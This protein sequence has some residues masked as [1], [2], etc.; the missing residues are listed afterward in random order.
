MDSHQHVHDWTTTSRHGT[1]EG[2]IAYERCRC[3][4]WRVRR[5]TSVRAEQTLMLTRAAGSA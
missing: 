4:Q 3:G 5:G 1:S 2:A